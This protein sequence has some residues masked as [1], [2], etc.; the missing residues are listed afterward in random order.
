MSAQ[1]TR[2]IIRYRKRWCV[3]GGMCTGSG[4]RNL[5]R[6]V[7]GVHGV[8]EAG[9]GAHRTAPAPVLL[10]GQGVRVGVGAVQVGGQQR[11]FAAVH[12]LRRDTHP[13]HF[14]GFGVGQIEGAH[15]LRGH[16]RRQP[17]GNTDHNDGA[18]A[19]FE[20]FVDFEGDAAAD[21]HGGELVAAGGADVDFLFV[22]L[23]GDGVEHGQHIDV[24]SVSEDEAAESVRV[25]TL[26]ALV[27]AD[28]FIGVQVTHGFSVCDGVGTLAQMT[29]LVSGRVGAHEVRASSPLVRAVFP[30]RR[31]HAGGSGGRLRRVRRMVCMTISA[32]SFAPEYAAVADAPRS[33]DYARLTRIRERLLALNYSYD[34]VQELLGVEAAEAMARDQVV[35]GLW[36]VEHILRGDY[37][38]EEKNLARLL[39]FFLLARPLTEAEAAEVFGD[40]LVDFEDAALIER[41]AADSARWSASVDLRP[42]AADDGTEIFVA[43]DLGAHQRPGVLRKDHVLGIGHASLTL[44]QITER[45]P[46]KR[47]LDVGTGC[48]IQTFHLL[49]HAEHVTATD[50]SE[51]ALAFTRFNLLLN[52]QALNIDPQNPQARVSLREGSLLE[53]VAGELFDLVVSNPPFVITPRVAGE[54]AEEQFTYRDGGLPGDEIVSTMVRQLPSVLVPGGRAQML[55]NWEI[56]RDSEDPEAPRPWDERPRA[57]VA[58]GG[59]EAWFIQREGLSP[60]SYAETWLKDASENRDRSHYEQTYVAY[61]NDFASRNVH[62]IGFGMIW[63]RRPTEATAAGVTE[64]LQRFEEITYPIQQPIARA[65]TESVRRYDRLAAMDDE[66]LLAAHLEVAED[67]TE[68]RHGRPG[69]E[70]PS[71]ILLRAGSGLCRTQLLSTETAGFAS[72][73]DGELAVGQIVAALAMLLSWPEYDE[74]AAA[75]RGTQEQHP[76]DTLLHAVRELVL[77][78]FLH[79][80]DE[81]AGAE[82]AGENTAEEQS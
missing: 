25:Q 69:A 28:T 76:R 5:C 48:G 16:F 75:A 42:H 33:D 31:V 3:H 34:A 79:F 13:L 50:I 23:V 32:A 12:G 72:A 70:H 24:L 8:H 80:S 44:A 30:T 38:V 36:R 27:D 37:S 40:T 35:P 21:H 66:A 73:S 81:H 18:D 45:T 59:A 41:D 46:V 55:G 47:A 6:Y 2:Y 64:P 67:V 26:P 9:A 74:A 56:I 78:S 15:N 22:V 77:K 58:D 11:V 71:V 20:G 68:E 1:G 39:A 17:V 43:A 62:S 4:A 51:R 7:H 29:V 49:A 63:L 57:W 52:A 60:A 82:S 10:A 61:L 14:V 54:S 19:V 53:P 65:L